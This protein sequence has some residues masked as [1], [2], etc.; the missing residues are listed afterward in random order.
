MI[1]QANLTREVEVLH[2]QFFRCDAPQ[3]LIE[4]YVRAHAELSDITRAS[5]SE[6]RTVRVI[7]EKELDALGIEPWLRSR[8][9]RHLLSRK[10]LLI[11]YLAECDA[12]HPE[13]REE[14][15]GSISSLVQLCRSSVLAVAHLVRGRLQKALYG[16]L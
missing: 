11:A 15:K 14:A 7:V 4:G 13:F 6:L 10:L 5:D 8:P 9:E 16:L 12:V 1:N 3:G 2:H